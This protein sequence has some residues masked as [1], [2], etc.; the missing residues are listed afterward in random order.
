MFVTQ[1][2]KHHVNASLFSFSLLHFY[3]RDERQQPCL[4][5]L[6]RP[7]HIPDQSEFRYKSRLLRRRRSRRRRRQLAGAQRDQCHADDLQRLRLLTGHDGHVPAESLGG[8]ERERARKQASRPPAARTPTSDRGSASSWKYAWQLA[9]RHR[10]MHQKPVA[11]SVTMTT[12]VATTVAQVVHKAE[13]GKPTW[14]EE[15]CRGVRAPVRAPVPAHLHLRPGHTGRLCC[16]CGPPAACAPG[17]SRRLLPA[18][19]AAAASAPPAAGAPSPG[20]QRTELPQ[21]GAPAEGKSHL[22]LL[23]APPYG[24]R[25]NGVDGRLPEGHL[26]AAPL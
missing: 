6:S 26:E 23:A 16:C 14:M 25:D 20:G 13:P 24:Y 18:G 11:N 15:G 10:L 7:R 2:R 22:Q 21:A 5:F 19:G 17:R 1:F 12:A 3:K 4:H 9:G 8:R